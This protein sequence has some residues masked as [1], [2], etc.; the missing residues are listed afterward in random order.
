MMYEGMTADGL[1]CFKA[2]RDRFNGSKRNPFNEPECGHHYARAMASWAGIIALSDFHYSG[3]TRQMSLT[4]NA[5]NY[6]WSNGYAWG[7]CRVEPNRVS[8]TVEGGKLSI[9]KLII[10]EKT[11]KVKRTLEN[12]TFTANL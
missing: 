1:K 10:G 8:L 3:V 2:V 9:D 7:T 6:F 11:L 12:E 4:H 5:G